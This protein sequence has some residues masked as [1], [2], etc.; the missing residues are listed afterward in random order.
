MC[1]SLRAEAGI[2]SETRICIWNHSQII[3]PRS[4]SL[5][6]DCTRILVVKNNHMLENH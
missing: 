5:D 6:M 3:N 1:G 4:V 2:G